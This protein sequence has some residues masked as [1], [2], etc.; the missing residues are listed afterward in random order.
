MPG[1]I[2]RMVGWNWFPNIADR[3]AMADIAGI[4]I[5]MQVLFLIFFLFR[6]GTLT[7]KGRSW[8]FPTPEAESF[9][10]QQKR[11]RGH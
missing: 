8:L 5:L 7:G 11:R 3:Q 2:Y 6:L 9:K 4:G 10:R 1:S